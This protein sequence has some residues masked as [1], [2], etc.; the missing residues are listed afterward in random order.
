MQKI[1]IADDEAN[2]LMLLEIM[3]KELDVEIISAENGEIALQ[4]AKKYHPDLVITDVVMPK[5]NGFEVC[6]ELR[7]LPEF[8]QIP[9]IILSALGDEYNKITGFEEGANDYIIKPF[10]VE[11]LKDRV[12]ALLYRN[13]CNNTVEVVSTDTPN[14]VRSDSQ[15]LSIDVIPTNIPQLDVNINGGIPRGSNI[16]ILGPIGRGKS[17][18]SRNFICDGL[19]NNEKCLF[20]ALDDDPNRIR[21]SLTM[22]LKE[23]DVAY[24]ENK[25]Q[26]GIVDAY[27]WSS[28][29]DTTNNETNNGF[30]ISG[31]LEL[32]QLA[33]VISDAGHEIGQTVQHKE[34]G[35]RVID[36]ISSLL[37][38]FELGQVQ[39]F[40]NQIARTSAAFGDVT[41]LFIMEEG[42]VQEQTLNNIKYIMD[43]VIEF[44][45]QEG[46]RTVRVSSMKWMKTNPEWIVI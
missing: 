27:S 38:N 4:K 26:F 46:Q 30:A 39:R 10:N 21:Q 29:T 6:R 5:K 1:L 15:D 12:K 20:V 7:D 32:N 14:V 17:S 11:E 19:N 9:I 13:Q 45:D 33:G 42:A 41:T 25:K 3:L 40:L 2:I 18:F 28:L 24:F 44:N 31:V 8:S 35:R 37:V 34:G 43:G 23:N 36:S 16:L 22:C